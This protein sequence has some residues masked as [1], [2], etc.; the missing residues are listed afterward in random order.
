MSRSRSLARRGREPWAAPQ[1]GARGY[2]GARGSSARRTCFFPFSFLFCFLFLSYFPFLIFS[3]PSSSISLSLSLP[4]FFPSSLPL[5]C[6]PF[7]SCP[8]SFLFPFSGGL[9]CLYSPVSGHP[10]LGPG[11]LGLG[12]AAAS[13]LRYAQLRVAPTA[14]YPQPQLAPFGL[15]SLGLLVKCQHLWSPSPGSPSFWL[16]RKP[17]IPWSG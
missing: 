2:V 3:F 7:P 12:E 4:F 1:T 17:L 9:L 6:F 16:L 5:R 11:H 14:L 15:A 8:L 10:A 13:L